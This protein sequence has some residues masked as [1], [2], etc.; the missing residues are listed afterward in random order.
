MARAVVP[1][2]AGHK[3]RRNLRIQMKEGSLR[4]ERKPT[5]GPSIEFHRRYSQTPLQNITVSKKNILEPL[6]SCAT[7]RVCCY[8][9]PPIVRSQSVRCFEGSF[10]RREYEES[11]RLVDSSLFVCAAF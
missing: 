9:P 11:D 10:T 4:C 8:N 5:Q 3:C 7:V 1:P 2:A 6:F